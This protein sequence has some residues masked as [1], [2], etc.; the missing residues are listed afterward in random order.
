M[1]VAI[2]FVAA[3]AALDCSS[4]FMVPVASRVLPS[5][6]SF[7]SVAVTSRAKT[8]D[9]QM[10]A[11]VVESKVS[12]NEYSSKS[13]LLC[14]LRLCSHTFYYC[15]CGVSQEENAVP[16]SEQCMHC[17]HVKSAIESAGTI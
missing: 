16:S 12:Q 9:L 6:P 14:V 3:S 8:P 15:A 1:R 4:A 5:R 10:S 11:T 13:K 17:E 2:A 7:G